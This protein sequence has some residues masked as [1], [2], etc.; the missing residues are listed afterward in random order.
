M[1]AKVK[2]SLSVV[3]LVNPKRNGI[4]LVMYQTSGGGGWEECVE[5][6]VCGGGGGG[7]GVGV[8]CKGE[9]SQ[10]CGI[11]HRSNRTCGRNS[12]KVKWC[13]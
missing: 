6:C 10:R 11:L 8:V 9:P 2:V 3:I 12:E 5:R 13:S 1:M 4:S 7:G